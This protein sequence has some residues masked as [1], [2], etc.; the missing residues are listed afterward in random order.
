MTIDEHTIKVSAGKIVTDKELEMG[1]EV[2]LFVT[3]EVIKVED[4][5]NF[6]G[7]ITRCYV[8]KGEIS[9]KME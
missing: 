7:T 9:E 3:G 4:T 6:D 2:R 1:S 8:V 5:N